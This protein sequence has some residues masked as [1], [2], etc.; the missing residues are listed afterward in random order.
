MDVIW[1]SEITWSQMRQRHHQLIVRFPPDRRIFFIEPLD[2]YNDFHISC[3]KDKNVISI[4]APTLINTR[5]KIAE[6]LLKQVW[7]R[8]LICLTELLYVKFLCRKYSVDKDDLLIIVSNIYSAD[9]V[10]KL[11]ARLICYDC[12]DDPLAFPFAP[13]WAEGYFY[14]LVNKA[15]IIFVTSSGLKEKIESLRKNNIYQI[16]NGVDASFF[17]PSVEE[18]AELKSVKRPIIGYVGHIGSWFDFDIVN[19][20]A[21]SFPEATV[22]L[23]GPTDLL[24]WSKLDNLK[25][26]SNVLTVGKIDYEKIPNY[27][28][29]FDVGLIP[30]K[31]NQ[32]TYSANPNKLYEYAACGI[33]VVATAFSPDIEEY[34]DAIFVSKDRKEFI[35]NL[36][37]ALVKENKK[38]QRER[39]RSIAL[40]NTW[41]KKANKMVEIIRG[42]LS[43]SGSG[44]L[45]G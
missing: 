4:P 5:F 2:I 45:S 43:D 7:F 39:L 31:C 36:K 24:V 22:V 11:G 30:F 25:Q 12:N 10:D 28:R 26:K 3:R 21:D 40:E 44:D 29:Q 19:G 9:V 17:N 6:K 37:R 35:D 16:G 14:K 18:P 20:L 27:I 1:F 32:L 8:K 34:S 13:S 42:Y 41:D 33:P 15:D 38:D 23:V